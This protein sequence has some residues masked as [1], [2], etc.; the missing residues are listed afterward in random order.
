MCVCG[1]SVCSFQGFQA[2]ANLWVTHSYNTVHILLDVTSHSAHWKDRVWLWWIEGVTMIIDPINALEYKQSS[3]RG[4]CKYLIKSK[5]E[6]AS[7]A[8]PCTRLLA[9]ELVS[10][11]AELQT[12]G[13]NVNP[14]I[15]TLIKITLNMISALKYANAVIID[16]ISQ[17]LRWSN[18]SFVT[19][20]LRL[21]SGSY[22]IKT[23]TRHSKSRYE[24]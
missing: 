8:A 14:S 4:R 24:E 13:W 16:M 9:A 20:T 18:L 23:Q 7:E 15:V 19:L 21:Q 11:C 2:T 12:W 1:G 5:I 17:R 22:K 3:L 10:E 6:T